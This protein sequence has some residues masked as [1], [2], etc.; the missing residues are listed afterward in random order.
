MGIIK[1]LQEQLRNT[2]EMVGGYTHIKRLD[3]QPLSV[4]TCCLRRAIE[5]SQLLSFPFLI[6]TVSR[7]SGRNSRHASTE[8]LQVMVII[9]YWVPLVMAV[10]YFE[11]GVLKHS[12]ITV[13]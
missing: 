10:H 3:K 11:Q 1:G 5:I 2:K 12:I 6:S 9:Y 8:L 4:I 13:L 7:L